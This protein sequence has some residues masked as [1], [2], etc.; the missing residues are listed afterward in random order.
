[1]IS[2]NGNGSFNVKSWLAIAIML[3]TII[4]AVVSVVAF[5]TNNKADIVYLKE[6]SVKHD[7]FEERINIC[8][9][10]NAL[11]QQSLKDI[12]EDTKEIRLDIKEIKR[13]K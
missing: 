1:M 5:S 2:N 11:I 13:E 9:R 12:K 10:N 8:E 4:S 7:S 3:I 6:K